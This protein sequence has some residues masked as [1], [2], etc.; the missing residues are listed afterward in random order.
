LISDSTLQGCPLS[1]GISDNPA[2]NTLQ[3]LIAVGWSSGCVVKIQGFSLRKRLTLA[4]WLAAL[5]KEGTNEVGGKALSSSA[6]LSFVWGAQ[7]AVK[8]AG[9]TV[10]VEDGML[11]SVGLGADLV[12]PLSWVFD[13]RGIYFDATRPSDLEHL[14]QTKDYS[15]DELARAARLRELLVQSRVTKYNLRGDAWQRPAQAQH[16]VLVA[17]QVESDASIALGCAQTRSNVQLLN[18]TRKRCPESY[19]VY[20][21][22][23]D[24]LA[25]LRSGQ[26]PPTPMG[27]YDEIV[28]D[29]D[30]NSM[31]SCVDELHVL[32]SLAGFEALLRGVKVV[33]YGMPFYAGWGLCDAPQLTPAV[34][35]RR[36]R[37]RSVDE[38]VAATLIDYA[39]Y[40]DPVSGRIWSAEEAVQYLAQAANA[41]PSAAAP[42][43]VIAQQAKRRLLAVYLKLLGRF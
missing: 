6:P 9:R 13:T 27:L 4:D 8:P 21:P 26:L 7:T 32:T 29:T 25:G 41:Q 36:G 42:L 11:R 43:Q 12:M 37:R 17:G 5:A 30:I 19:I 24:V 33:C 16:V 31:Y 15:A 10:H 28:T 40:R 34:A 23:P 20:K 18:E 22:H 2:M 39:S 14:L 35:Q 38:L 1:L 3:R